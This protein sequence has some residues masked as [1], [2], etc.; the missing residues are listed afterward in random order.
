MPP[1]RAVQM[2]MGSVAGDRRHHLILGVPVTLDRVVLECPGRVIAAQKDTLAVGTRRAASGIRGRVVEVGHALPVVGRLRITDGLSVALQPPIRDSG[3][4][5][6]GFVPGH[7]GSHRDHL[8]EISVESRR[9]YDFSAGENM[10]RVRE[11]DRHD[12]QRST[13]EETESDAH[14]DS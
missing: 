12:Q 1:G 10:E 2:G 3:R 13:Q 7:D 11:R 5:A 8:F 9:R 4:A 6:H 14:S